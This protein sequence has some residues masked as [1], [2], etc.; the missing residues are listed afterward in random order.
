MTE[1]TERELGTLTAKLDALCTLVRVHNER[2]ERWQ[3]NLD[4]KLFG[5]EGMFAQHSARL[6]SLERWRDGSAA[7]VASA[8]VLAAWITAWWSWWSS[9]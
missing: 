4:I 5:P 3:T 1:S 6:R 9:R 2:E 8:G 7:V